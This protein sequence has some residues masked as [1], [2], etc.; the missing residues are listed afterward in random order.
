MW[1]R[2]ELK[3]RAK[4]ILRDSYWK[5]FL[6]SF[7]ISM[8]AGRTG[9]NSGINLRNWQNNFEM[10]VLDLSFIGWYLLGALACGIG[11]VFVRPYDDATHG[12][13]YLKL[14]QQAI[15]NGFCD[16]RELKL[17]RELKQETEIF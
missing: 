1:N 11:V 12:E 16:Y 5:A 13:L 4:N 2:G 8:I 17:V 9:S 14:R 6:V 15:E 3:Q 10:W 7:V